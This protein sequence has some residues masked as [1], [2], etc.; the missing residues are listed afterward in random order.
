MI[1]HKNFPLAFSFNI[2]VSVELILAAKWHHIISFNEIH[3]KSFLSL[4]YIKARERKQPKWVPFSIFQHLLGRT[5]DTLQITTWS[6]TGSAMHLQLTRVWFLQTDLLKR[7]T[8][9]KWKHSFHQ[10]YLRISSNSESIEHFQIGNEFSLLWL[11]KWMCQMTYYI[12]ALAYMHTY[13][14][15]N[16]SSTLQLNFA[17]I[18]LL[19]YQNKMSQMGTNPQSQ[20]L[21]IFQFLYVYKEMQDL[22]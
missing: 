7:L 19:I 18:Y 15:A 20:N 13:I 3:L 5:G 22:H 10:I 6:L 16:S 14:P 4:G 21:A 8:C 9:F 12:L 2:E 17:P 1:W 11:R